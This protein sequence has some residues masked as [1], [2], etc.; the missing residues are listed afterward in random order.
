MALLGK[1]VAG[2]GRPVKE[3]YRAVIVF[4]KIWIDVDVAG[5]LVNKP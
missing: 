2:V 5:R 3:F 1:Y 4:A